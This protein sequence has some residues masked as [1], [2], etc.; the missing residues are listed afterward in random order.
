MRLCF[1]ILSKG[2]VVDNVGQVGHGGI[3]VMIL[4]L[5]FNVKVTWY[6][7]DH[8]ITADLTT[9]MVGA[10]VKLLALDI[11]T[12]FVPIFDFFDYVQIALREGDESSYRAIL[13]VIHKHLHSGL[14]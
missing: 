8:Q 12:I 3:Q 10:S 11:S 14:K 9:R 13:L 6:P 2:Q 7:V 1:N 5:C 4:A